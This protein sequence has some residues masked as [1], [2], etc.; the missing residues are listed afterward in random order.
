MIIA[1]IFAVGIIGTRSSVARDSP[2][3]I[4]YRDTNPRNVKPPH[5]FFEREQWGGKPPFNRT[6]LQLPVDLVVIA[7]TVTPF[8]GSF[9]HCSQIVASIQEHHLFGLNISDIGYNFVIGG[10]GNIY[11]GRGWD[12][13]NFQR[14]Q[15]ISVSFIGNFVLDELNLNMIDAFQL[16]MND[17]VK[18]GKLKKNYKLN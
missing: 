1:I 11:V 18:K 8:C 13:V 15:S 7:H 12:T 5:Q 6:Q 17:G 2:L 4:P 10:D 14:N 16:L 3:I 9:T